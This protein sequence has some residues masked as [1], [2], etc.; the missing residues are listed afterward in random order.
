MGGRPGKIK[1]TG[2]LDRGRA[3]E[4]ADAIALAEA[5]R[6]PADI[7]AVRHYTSRPG[8]SINLE[9]QI[10]GSLGLFARAGW[11]DGKVEPWDF[12]DVD[13]TISGG[14]SLK[15]PS[16]GRPNDTV[17]LGGVIN[18]ISGA[19]RAFLNDG[20]LGILVGDGQ[21]PHP[22]LEKIIETYYSYAWNTAAH[23]SADY[24]FIDPYRSSRC[25]FTSKIDLAWDKTHRR[26]PPALRDTL[27][28]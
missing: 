5:T 15:G 20:G 8:I 2:F 25:A 14:L 21:L 26:R 1:I 6:Q 4:Y 12:T 18:D 10:T 17:G 28:Y 24:Q 3:G 27:R 16:W 7:T 11:A 13:R 22:G 9:Q 23:I 19:H